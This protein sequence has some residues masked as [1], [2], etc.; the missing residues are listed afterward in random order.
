MS[1]AYG[2]LKHKAEQF[3]GM[4]LASP[5]AED[6]EKNVLAHAYTSALLEVANCA[7]PLPF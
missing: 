3:T 1:A 5:L 6:D 2:M 4:F 7:R